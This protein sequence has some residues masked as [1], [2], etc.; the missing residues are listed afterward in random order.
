MEREHAC[1]CAC[2]LEFHVVCA[3]IAYWAISSVLVC[4]WGYVCVCVEEKITHKRMGWLRSVGSIKL[5]VSYAEYC[6]FYRALLQ[7]R[8]VILSI[9]LTKAT[10][11]P[12]TRIKTDKIA[13]DMEFQ[14]TR[15]H[16]HTLSLH[17]SHTLSLSSPR[18]RSPSPRQKTSPA[19]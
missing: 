12:H 6:L 16:A 14:H 19:T 1:V 17:H 3:G 13:N 7:K 4:V 9:L 8:S 18:S 5:Y 15:T 2:V 10:P 11:Y